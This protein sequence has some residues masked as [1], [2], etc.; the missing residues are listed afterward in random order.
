MSLYI[1]YSALEN[2]YTDFRLS[3]QLYKIISAT[4]QPI[5]F[6]SYRE[7]FGLIQMHF[8][9]TITRGF[10]SMYR[11]IRRGG[12]FPIM[13]Y[14]SENNT[15]SLMQRPQN[16]F[17]TL[18]D[19]EIDFLIE[20]DNEMLDRYFVYLKYYCT[21]SGS[22]DATAD[23]IL[24]A[25]HYSPGGSNKQHLSNFNKILVQHGMLYIKHTYDKKGHLRN[26]YYISKKWKPSLINQPNIKNILTLLKQNFIEE[27][28]FVGLIKYRFDFFVNNSYVIEY[29]GKQHFYPVKA[30]GGEE[31]Y[32]KI[33]QNDIIKNQYCF[34]HNIPI[35]RIPY[36]AEYTAADL[37]LETTRFLLTPENEK[38]YYERG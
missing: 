4:Q 38:E 19:N 11:N 29:D 26:T 12:L 24:N 8:D 34:E 20:Q 15:I 7:L 27:Y 21:L 10:S 17:T 37:L 13:N 1:P 23:Q 36:D 30:F 33:H 35:I 3:F 2:D 25:L 5:T 18:L 6:S 9:A 16:N 22:T 31:A 28:R 32:S 14:S